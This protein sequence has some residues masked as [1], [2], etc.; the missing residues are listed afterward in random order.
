MN[1][2]KARNGKEAELQAYLSKLYIPDS[3]GNF[4]EES[5][6]IEVSG[7]WPAINAVIQEFSYG[8]KHLG[9]VELKAR[10]TI[11]RQGHLWQ[12]QKLNVINQDATLYSSGSWLKGFDG[13]NTTTLLLDTKISN[14]GGLLDRLGIVKVVRRGNGSVKGELSWEGSPLGYNANT[15]DGKLSI[16]LRRGE[17]LKIEPGAAKLLTLLSL[18]SLTRY[19]RLDFRDFYSKGFN[20]DS[21]VGSTNMNNGLMRLDDLTMVGSGATVVMKGDIN[22]RNETEDLHILV[23]PDINATGASIALAIANPIAGIGSF[24]AQLI[25]KDPLSK[26]F[27]F[28]Y[29]VTG[30]WSDPVVKKLDRKNPF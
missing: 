17:I 10:N 20:F 18:Q 14:L 28:E 2:N 23:L 29:S 9:K 15:F 19:L 8:K 27:S 12:I 25:F 5:K 1:W 21:I 30:T 4:A 22:V 11:S 6:P 3:A 7:G 24:L 26:L 13:Q 16:D